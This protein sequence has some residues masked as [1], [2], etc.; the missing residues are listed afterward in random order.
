[1]VRTA[2]L[3][4]E[5]TGHIDLTAASGA[6]HTGRRGVWSRRMRVHAWIT[7]LALRLASIA[8]KRFGVALGSGRFRRRSNRGRARKCP[9]VQC[10]RRGVSRLK[11]GDCLGRTDPGVDS[12]AIPQTQDLIR[13]QTNDSIPI[14]GKRHRQRGSVQHIVS[15]I[16]PNLADTN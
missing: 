4:A 1:V 14:E 7:E 10:G 9:A 2:G 13:P 3:R 8:R 16:R 6:H 12:G 5:M 15:V 11:P